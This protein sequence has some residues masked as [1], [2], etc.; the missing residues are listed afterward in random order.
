MAA[1]ARHNTDYERENTDYERNRFEG[2][3]RKRQALEKRQGKGS[4]DSRWFGRV[5]AAEG[6]T[7]RWNNNNYDQ[8]HEDVVIEWV[9]QQRESDDDDLGLSLLA[10]VL[11]DEITKKLYGDQA[12]RKELLRALPLTM[13]PALR[14]DR[15][16][17]GAVVP[18]TASRGTTLQRIPRYSF[19][20]RP[21]VFLRGVLHMRRRLPSGSE[22]RKKLE[23]AD[24][25]LRRIG[26][27]S[28]MSEAS[29]KLFDSA[30]E[31]MLK[32]SGLDDVRSWCEIGEWIVKKEILLGEETNERT[33]LLER[34]EWFVF[35]PSLFEARV[36]ARLGAL[37][38]GQYVVKKDSK[39]LRLYERHKAEPDIVVY[40]NGKPIAIYEV[41]LYK[42]SKASINHMY[43]I[44]S[45]IAAV[46]DDPQNC[47]H[48]GLIYGHFEGELP[49]WEAHVYHID[50]RGGKGY[51]EDFDATLKELSVFREA[52]V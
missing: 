7:E 18:G 46:F 11:A 51:A 38:G 39:K 50:L 20:T 45:Q 9:H 27:V 26:V 33:Y 12:A 23:K 52:S 49:K 22:V 40:K 25:A 30:K 5:A 44:E 16:R 1:Q 14:R 42:S 10:Q 21:L 28:V 3:R 2:W 36:R 32:G 34:V 8:I 15:L 37:L 43:Q 24:K 35:L 4:D 13:R 48:Y 6:G 29:L 19:N 47:R 31:R 41:K 17:L